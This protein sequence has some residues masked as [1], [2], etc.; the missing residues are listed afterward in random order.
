MSGAPLTQASSPPRPQP[1]P[2]GRVLV[3]LRWQ[4][5]ELAAVLRAG[6]LRPLFS[7]RLG[8]ADF[9]P[10]S[11]TAVLLLTER[12]LMSP[13]LCRRRLVTLAQASMPHKVAV[14]ERT[15]VTAAP[16]SELQLE[17]ALELRLAALPVGSLAELPQLLAELAAAAERGAPQ[18]LAGRPADEP[19]AARRVAAALTAVPGL[20]AKKADAL[21]AQFGSLAALSA[22]AAE[23]LAPLLG[24]A[25]A[26]TVHQFF[27][28]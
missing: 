6:T 12:D 17:A 2:P 27:N 8:V 25:L 18:P 5:S 16:W 20:G 9:L 28:G 14:L 13:Q 26:Q 19:P 4:G 11:D 1:V 3:S 10:A 7:D 22:A 23:Q 21:L 15:P 24:P